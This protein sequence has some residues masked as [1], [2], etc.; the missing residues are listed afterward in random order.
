[1]ASFRDHPQFGNQVSVLEDAWRELKQT[2][3]AYQAEP[4]LEGHHELFQ[5]AERLWILSNELVLAAQ[6]HAE[7]KVHNYNYIVASFVVCII[8]IGALLVWLKQYVHDSL[9][10][11]A[12]HDSLTRAANRH[13]F[14][15]RMRTARFQAAWKTDLFPCCSWILTTS[16]P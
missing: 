2:I 12:S 10:Y 15:E 6:R 5:I 3:L 4:T 11:L 14:H 9:E 13:F 8:L 7:S 16:K 1:M